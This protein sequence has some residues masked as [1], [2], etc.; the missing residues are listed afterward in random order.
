MH[1]LIIFAVVGFVVGTILGSLAKVLAD[2][3]LEGRTFKGRSYCSHCKHKLGWYDLLPIFS[4]LLLW[5][6][7]RYCRKK[8]GHEYLWVELG[9]GAAVAVLFWQEALRFPGVADYFRLAIFILELTFKTF[10]LTALAALFITDLR[11]MLLP[12]RITLP[13]IAAS[14]V[15]LIVLTVIKIGYFY[16]YLSQTILGKYLLPPHSDYFQRHAW[17]TL[18]PVLWSTISAVAIGIFFTGLIILTKGK[19]MGGGDVKL[20]VLMG[21]VLGFPGSFLALMLAFLTGATLSLGLIALGK[22]NFGDTLAFGP[23]L[24]LGSYTSLLW[25]EEIISWYLS[26]SLR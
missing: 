15:F 14:L 26:L 10:F 22:K 2:R 25:G 18:E 12:D 8:I 16:Y 3:S 20:G 24:I 4:Y 13:A 17:I 23:F 5:G 9:L 19:G 11:K 21:L 1:L 7:C 6:R